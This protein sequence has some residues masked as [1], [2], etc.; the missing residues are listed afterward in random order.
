MQ[1]NPSQKLFQATMATIAATAITTGATQAAISMA[2][3]EPTGTIRSDNY[4]YAG[5]GFFLS[6]GSTVQINQLGYWDNDSDGLSNSHVVSVFKYVADSFKSY[7]QIASTSIPSGTGATLENGY[8]WVSIP[9]LTL[10]ENGQN[11]NY[12]VIMASHGGDAWTTGL[13]SGAPMDISF[14]TLTANGALDF[15]GG[16]NSDEI[17]ST[18]NTVYG[19]ANF[20][21]AVPEPSVALSAGVSVLGFAF[22]R[23]RKFR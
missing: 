15:G 10:T 12:Y 16:P 14:G 5:Y 2:V 8:R 4:A 22:V 7:T 18:L 1:N 19:G 13:G 21:Y 20:G 3:G 17:N 9:E 23:R 6:P 11:G